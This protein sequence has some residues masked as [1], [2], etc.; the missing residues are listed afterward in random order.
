MCK[1]FC[2]GYQES[3]L[4][5]GCLHLD[6]LSLPSPSSSEVLWWECFSNGQ[7]LHTYSLYC[8]CYW[9]FFWIAEQQCPLWWAG[10]WWQYQTG[11]GA[12]VQWEEKWRN[13]S[14]LDLES[15]SMNIIS[16]I[17]LTTYCLHIDRVQKD[18]VDD[19]KDEF[20]NDPPSDSEGTE[21]DSADK[22]CLA[23]KH[24][25]NKSNQGFGSDGPASWDCRVIYLEHGYAIAGWALSLLPEVWDDVKQ[26]M[27]GQH[28]DAIERVIT[29]LHQPPFPNASNDI[30]ITDITGVLDI[31][32]DEFDQFKSQ[33][34]VYKNHT[35]FLTNDA[36]KGC[37]HLWHKKY[38][39]P[40]TQVL[41]YVWCHMT[42]KQLGTIHKSMIL[43][44]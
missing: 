19:T 22:T 14:V 34:G 21:E 43:Q 39:L 44:P 26:R 18:K 9:E 27:N 36:R 5:E 7:D 1:V 12:G 41:G 42:G 40:Y 17:C 8:S 15:I 29:K 31:F 20:H 32:W 30:D 4:L 11:A 23:I 16:L 38:L 28:R 24:K 2:R 3:K 6:A 10:G 13:V 25:S 33:K 37:L 35:Q